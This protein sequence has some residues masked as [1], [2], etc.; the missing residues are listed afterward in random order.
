MLG[1]KAGRVK[2]GRYEQCSG[3]PSEVFRV[4]RGRPV[5]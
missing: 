5:Q 1:G 4:T 2:A 3:L